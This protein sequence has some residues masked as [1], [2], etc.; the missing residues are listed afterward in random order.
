MT[1]A[2]RSSCGSSTS[3]RD[4]PSRTHPGRAP[5]AGRPVQTTRPASH[6]PPLQEPGRCS[7]PRGRLPDVFRCD[8]GTSS[9]SL[10]GGPSQRPT[11][12]PNVAQPARPGSSHQ[13]APVSQIGGAAV[14][15]GDGTGGVLAA[16]GNLA[17]PGGFRA[18]PTV[19]VSAPACVCRRLVGSRL[20]PG[21]SV[22]S[23]WPT[24]IVSPS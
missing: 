24:L 9:P 11:R 23:V 7:L 21:S 8:P 19:G 14:V 13:P 4:A 22:I 3:A 15:G 10:G 2:R 6:S 1:S 5:R 16:L 17:W 18:T 12:G 20:P